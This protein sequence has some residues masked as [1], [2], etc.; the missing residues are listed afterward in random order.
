[1]GEVQAKGLKG[2]KKDLMGE[3]RHPEAQVES[4]IH[5][6]GGR[7]DSRPETWS[8]RV[9]VASRKGV[10]TWNVGWDQITL[11]CIIGLRSLVSTYSFPPS[12]K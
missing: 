7:R 1:M 12:N 9:G 8:Q 2:N 3:A 11:D 6:Q 4:G 10:W 5:K